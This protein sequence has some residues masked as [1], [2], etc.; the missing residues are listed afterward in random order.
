[1]C[2]L[3]CAFLTVWCLHAAQIRVYIEQSR[4]AVGQHF[5]V[6]FIVGPKCL[7]V[8][9]ALREVDRHGV[10]RGDFVLVG[11]VPRVP[12]QPRCPETDSRLHAPPLT[13]QISGDI[14]SNVN[15][16]PIVE[17]HR[18]RYKRDPGAI[19][20]MVCKQAGPSHHIRGPEDEITMGLDSEDGRLIYYQKTHGQDTVELPMRVLEHPS[21]SLRSGLG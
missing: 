5:Q 8:G 2:A 15:L 11:G 14:V 3:R 1:M 17:A 16:A 7:T 19:M 10:V 12:G 21:V 18:D 4:W 13:L 6:E 20:T 9:D